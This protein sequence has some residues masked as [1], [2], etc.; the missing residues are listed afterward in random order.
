MIDFNRK[1][2][3]KTE[4]EKAFDAL[5]NEYYEKFG[6]PYVFSFCVSEMTWT[7]TLADIRR[8]IA[9]NDPQPQPDYE[10][11]NVY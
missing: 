8:R 6:V 2:S 4:E 11:G 3:P 1:P 10:P 9:E 5:N 7:E